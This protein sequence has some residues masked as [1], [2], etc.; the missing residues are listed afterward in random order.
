M[1]DQPCYRLFVYGS[2]RKGFE[3]PAYGYISSHFDLTSPATV[4]GRLYDL[5]D[6]PAGVPYEAEEGE[7]RIVGELYTIRETDEFEWAIAQLD[8]Y[9]GVDASYDEPAQYYRSRVPVLCEDG[10]T[11]EAWIYW[12]KGT[13]E[14]KPLVASGDILEYLR[15][16][17]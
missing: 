6:Y 7:A 11:T 13:V 9:E 5:G 1:N 17:Q 4:K 3:S 8:D 2:L 12:Y 14:G 10:Q 15:Q 16:R